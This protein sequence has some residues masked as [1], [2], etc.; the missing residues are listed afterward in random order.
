MAKQWIIV[1]RKG[2]GPVLKYTGTK[3]SDHGRVK[4]FADSTEAYKLAHR[5]IREYPVLKHYTL[6]VRPAVSS[7]PRR[8]E[9]AAHLLKEFSGHEAAEVLRVDEPAFKDG[10]VIGPLHGLLY[11]TVRDGR[12]ENYIHRF[13]KKS[14]PLL[15]ASSDGTRLRI[16]GG[17]FQFTEAGIED[18]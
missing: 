6:S 1:A 9:S 4:Q 17:R 13:A 18:R 5:L 15:A 3:F 11:G 16:V 12:S 8:L 2:S 10:L 7:V 14:R